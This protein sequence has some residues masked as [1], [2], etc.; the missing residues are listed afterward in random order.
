MSGISTTVTAAP[1]NNNPA[2]ASG[3]SGGASVVGMLAVGMFVLP[4]GLAAVATAGVIKGVAALTKLGLKAYKTHKANQA[5]KDRAYAA[6]IAEYDA[7]IRDTEQLLGSTNSAAHIPAGKPVSPAVQKALLEMQEVQHTQAAQIR[8][9]SEAHT[10]A[11]AKEQQRLLGTVQQSARRFDPGEQIRNVQNHLLEDWKRQT[12]TLRREYA[13]A[14]VKHTESAGALL[15]DYQSVQAEIEQ[16]AGQQEQRI[17]RQKMLS[18]QAL[19]DAAAMLRSFTEQRGAAVL[20][21][22]KIELFRQHYEEAGAFHAAG[23]YEAAYDKAADMLLQMREEMYDTACGTALSDLENDRLTAYAA[24]L[25]ES[26]SG[27]KALHYEADGVQYQTVDLTA[28]YPEAFAAAEKQLSSVFAVLAGEEPLTAQMLERLRTKLRETEIGISTAATEARRRLDARRQALDLSGD[29]IRAMSTQNFQRKH[30][31]IADD[32]T[33]KM[34]FHNAANNQDVTTLTRYDR[35]TL[36]FRLDHFGDG[37]A[38]SR[39]QESLRKAVERETGLRLTC[40]KPGA[41]SGAQ[42]LLHTQSKQTLPIP[43]PIR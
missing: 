33:L 35:G 17:Q 30:S 32:G 37:E 42:D 25:S 15:A 12:D 2:S 18:E 39:M 19:T 9:F 14:A 16:Y 11:F 5:E 8:A 34:V 36:Q 43:I 24:L 10:A 21:S 7:I 27:M 23:N 41:Y 1:A 22:D 31:S 20:A 26:I 6:R 40:C 3:G 29:V 4:V 28:Y 13:D 38:D